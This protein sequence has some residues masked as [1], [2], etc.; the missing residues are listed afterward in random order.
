MKVSIVTTVKEDICGFVKTYN[1]VI[2]QGYSNIEYIVIDASQNEKIRESN[3]EFLEKIDIFVE[4]ADSSPYEG[5]N[6]GI[7]AATGE[8]IAL[9]HAGDFYSSNS[10]VAQIVDMFK[11]NNTKLVY[12]DI[13]Y[14]SLKNSN[15]VVRVWK[16]ERITMKSLYNGIFPPHPS[17][18]VKKELYDEVGRYDTQYKIAADSDFMFRLFYR[19]PPSFYLE[20]EILSMRIGG[21][22]NRSLA[23]IYNSN[24]EFYKILKKNGVANPFLKTLKKIFSK[25]KQLFNKNKE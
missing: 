15:K 13:V 1:S 6:K 25:S 9:L 7:D 10:I 24:V 21:R 20:K 2:S 16:G 8:I 3:P 23:A 19:D 4:E 5:M 12:G 11:E 18:F 17:L 22:S 14:H